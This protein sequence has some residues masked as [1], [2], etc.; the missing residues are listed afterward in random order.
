MGI[1]WEFL[2]CHFWLFR[3]VS[4]KSNEHVEIPRGAGVCRDILAAFGWDWGM[5]H[6]GGEFD[7]FEEFFEEF[8]EK[9]IY[10][11]VIWV[12]DVEDL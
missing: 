6:N 10:F 5:A 11:I 1:W 12:H 8:D 9:R 3:E 7:V 4:V 2:L